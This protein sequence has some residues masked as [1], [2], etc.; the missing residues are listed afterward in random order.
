MKQPLSRSVL[1]VLASPTTVARSMNKCLY[2]ECPRC[3]RYDVD[4]YRRTIQ[5]SVTNR[6]R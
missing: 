5:R 4:S 2:T 3:S 6:S 1:S